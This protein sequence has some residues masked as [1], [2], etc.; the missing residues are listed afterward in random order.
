MDTRR[1]VVTGIGAVTPIGIGKQQVWESILQCRRAGRRVTRFDPTPYHSKV[2][3]EVDN[4]NPLDFIDAKRAR[5]LD[6]FSQFSLAAGRLAVE[7]ARLDMSKEQRDR[8]GVY[9]GSALGGIAFAEEQHVDFVAGGLRSVNP[10]LALAVFSGASSANVAM[11]I[12]ANGPS[13]GN[14]N[15]CASGTIGIGEAF[16]AIK[17]GDVD[18]AI[19]GGVEAPLAPLTFGAFAIIKVMSTRNDHPEEASR[20]FDRDRDGFVMGEGA[21]LL[22]LEEIGHAVRRDAT[23]YA[24]VLGFGVTSDAFHMTAPRPDALESGRSISLALREANLPPEAIDYVA[25]HAS[26]TVLNDK[27]ETLAIKH[28]LGD[29]AYRIPISGTKGMHAHALG[30][31]GAIELVICALAMQYDVIP[32]TVNFYDPDPECDLSY[33]RDRPMEQRVTYLLKNSFGFGGVNAT[34]VLGRV[35]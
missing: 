28:A 6:R 10:M 32:A 21:G 5:R 7:D 33:V 29:H 8:V 35:H 3:A 18:V 2:A 30:A 26:S 14:S 31:S 20:P 9:I 16:R 1:V 25:A 11:D 12:G 23:I 19:A 22:V 27:T 15:S 17:Y 4:F 34:L 13:L 24:E